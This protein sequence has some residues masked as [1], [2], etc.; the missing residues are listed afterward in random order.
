M[1][2]WLKRHRQHGKL[3]IHMYEGGM[4]GTVG[5]WRSED[6]LGYWSAPSTLL[7]MGLSFATV[8]TV[9]ASWTLNFWDSVSAPIL[10]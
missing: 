6:N 4:P 2:G 10:L 1:T 5:M 7:E 9:E 8:Y 3:T